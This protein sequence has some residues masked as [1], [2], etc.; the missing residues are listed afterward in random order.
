M[1]PHWVVRLV[2]VAC[3]SS[4]FLAPDTTKHMRNQLA[5]SVGHGLLTELYCMMV[6]KTS[7]VLTGQDHVATLIPNLQCH[8]P[9][10]NAMQAIE[11]LFSMQAAFNSNDES[12]VNNE[13]ID[14]YLLTL[15]EE[16]PVQQF[17]LQQ[18]EVAAVRSASSSGLLRIRFAETSRPS[19]GHRVLLAPCSWQHHKHPCCMMLACLLPMYW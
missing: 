13:F 3:V 16:I 14:V 12:F 15:K 8:R 1:R 9:S 4:T 10:M 6:H 2:S 5:N 19:I 11:P 17:I 18:E 7:E